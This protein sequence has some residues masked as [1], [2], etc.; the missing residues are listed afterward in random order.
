MAV[1]ISARTR[2]AA[3]LAASAVSLSACAGS[4]TQWMVNLRTSQGDSAL[5]QS[6]LSEA[7][8]EY[9]LALKLDPKDVQARTGLAKVLL[10][11]ARQDFATSRLD[12]A[13]DAINLALKYAP[14]D[15]PT[16][17]LAAQI[18][19]AKIRR[20]I[21]LANYPLYASVGASLNDSMKS[22]TATQR[23][24]AK[25]LKAFDNDF[26]TAHLT[27]AIVEAYDLEDGAHRLTSR[28]VGYR[29][30]V[31]SGAPKSGAPSQSEVPNLLPVP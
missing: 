22:L 23:D 31:S 10:L 5:A 21:V 18:G 7:Q 6:S 19:Q 24:V 27:R 26:D 2:A 28:I 14:D 11:Q 25:Q 30:L 9:E 15:V 29:D 3:L 8:K 16:Q 17:A 12:L 20:E 4:M 1:C 13:G